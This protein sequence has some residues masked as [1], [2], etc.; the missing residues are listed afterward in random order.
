MIAGGNKTALV[1]ACPV[2]LRG[3]TV[4]ELLRDVEQV[5]FIDQVP[6][7]TL[8][9]MGNEL[10]VNALLATGATSAQSGGEFRATGVSGLVTYEKEGDEIA[11]TFDAPYRREGDCIIFDGI[12]FLGTDTHRVL[13]KAEYRAYAEQYNVPA[14]GLIQ[15]QGSDIVPFVYVMETDTL[16]AETACGSGS[17]ALHI[18]TGASRVVQ[19]TGYTIEVNLMGTRCTVRARV[20][21]LI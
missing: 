18:L 21:C 6:Q 16:V 4:H 1:S 14:F 13:T 5:G 9:M 3:Q 12:G 19:P 17:V 2:S 10:C 15:Y 8:T 11:V 20:E 7:V